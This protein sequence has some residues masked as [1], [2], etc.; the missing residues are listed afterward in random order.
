MLKLIVLTGLALTAM[1][2]TAQERYPFCE[3]YVY[4]DT[5][6]FPCLPCMLTVRRDDAAETYYLTSNNGWTAELEW[7]ETGP[8]SAEGVGRWAD[9]AGEMYG[10]QTFRISAGTDG[11]DWLA[12]TMAHDASWLAPSINLGFRCAE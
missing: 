6:A 12:V 4:A 1:P 7:Y 8:D 2:A 9:E 10:G 3:T 11:P 5:T